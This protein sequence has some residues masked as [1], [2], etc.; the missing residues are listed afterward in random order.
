MRKAK[1]HQRKPHGD[2]HLVVFQDGREFFIEPP[3]LTARRG[4]SVLP[5]ALDTGKIMFLFP[6]GILVGKNGK[7]VPQLPFEPANSGKT[8][9][10][11]SKR[12]KPGCYS[13]AVSCDQ[14]RTFARGGS[15]PKIIIYE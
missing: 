5:Y 4:E 11:V 10:T 13:Y 6:D 1:T 9:L 7:P 2:H 12:A 15:N 3:R 14:G 8:T